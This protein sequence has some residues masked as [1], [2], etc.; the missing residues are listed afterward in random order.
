MK[1]RQI[2]TIFLVARK[3][4]LIILFSGSLV[5]GAINN[6]VAAAIDTSF[7]YTLSNFSGTVPYNWGRVF[8]DKERD[9]IYVLYKNII[10]VFN[11]SGMEIYR[12][13]EDFDLGLIYDAVLDR[14]GDILMLTYRGSEYDIIRCNFRGDPLG[15]IEIKNLPSEFSDLSPD[16]MDYRD[17]KLYLVSRRQMKIIVTSDGQFET[18]YDFPSLLNLSEKER[19]STEINGFSVDSNGNILFTIAVLFK[20]F[21]L[22][23]DGEIESFGTPGGTPG[24]FG[25]VSGIVSDSHGNYLVADQLKSAVMVFNS[26][27]ELLTQFGFRGVGPGSLIRPRALTIDSRDRVYVTNGARRGISVF[28]I[29][30]P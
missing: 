21:K 10:S 8:A 27:Y 9:E 7:L 25:V 2:K 19:Q 23:P 13:G 5:L 24:K 29:T 20:A 17:G 16:R 15:K 1:K 30:Y 4:L 3:F 6:D 14:K 18:G 28:K 22:S 26:N 11:S 12:F